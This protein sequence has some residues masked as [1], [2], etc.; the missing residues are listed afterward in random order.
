MMIYLWCMSV[1]ILKVVEG[2]E[3]LCGRFTEYS[4]KYVKVL[5]EACKRGVLVEDTLAVVAKAC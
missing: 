3:E 1:C 4:L 2:T 5:H